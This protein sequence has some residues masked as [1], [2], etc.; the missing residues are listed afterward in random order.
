MAVL[1]RALSCGAS[2]VSTRNESREHPVVP[3]ITVEILGTV[4]DTPQELERCMIIDVR[5]PLEYRQSHIPG[6]E[7]YHRSLFEVTETLHQVVDDVALSGKK[8]VVVYCHSGRRGSCCVQRLMTQLQD[9]HTSKQVEVKLLQ[10]GYAAWM[11]DTHSKNSSHNT[12]E[13]KAFWR[14]FQ[15]GPCNRFRRALQC[16]RSHLRTEKSDQQASQLE[17]ASPRSVMTTDVTPLG[18][19]NWRC[20]GR[21]FQCGR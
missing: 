19:G 6:A 16:G 20:F 12:A 21:V 3:G 13:P 1:E 10:G 5:D 18:K 14:A 9:K 8:L 7:H 17:T 2:V 15:V 4:L 11:K